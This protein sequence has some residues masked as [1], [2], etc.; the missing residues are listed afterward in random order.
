M[1]CVVRFMFVFALL[2]AVG[3]SGEAFANTLIPG[4]GVEFTNHSGSFVFDSTTAFNSSDKAITNIGH[5]WMIQRFMDM[6]VDGS[7]NS[8]N[9]EEAKSMPPVGGGVGRL[10]ELSRRERIPV[11]RT[12]T[13]LI[14]L[15]AAAV[16][17]PT[18]LLLLGSGLLPL[19]WRK[20][21]R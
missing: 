5:S 13:G 14:D 7:E 17:E 10:I 3:Q 21:N 1:K 8:L 9:Y 6:S 11:E 19:V 20:R 16:P 2:A 15:Q 12:A 4:R 18:S